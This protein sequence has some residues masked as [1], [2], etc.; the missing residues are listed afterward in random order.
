M[1]LWFHPHVMLINCLGYQI[2]GE[3]WDLFK[4]PLLFLITSPKYKDKHADN[5]ITTHYNCPISCYY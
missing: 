5:F 1:P 2:G 4:G 3:I